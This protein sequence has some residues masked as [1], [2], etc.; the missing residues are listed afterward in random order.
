[1]SVRV[2]GCRCESGSE[3]R[4]GCWCV[5]VDL[6]VGASVDVSQSVGVGASVNVGQSLDVGVVAN[7]GISDSA[8]AHESIRGVEFPVWL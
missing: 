4:Y 7:V 3:C 6:G 2:C 5:D 1:M 8:A